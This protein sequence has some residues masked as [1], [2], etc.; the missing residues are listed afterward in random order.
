VGDAVGDMTRVYATTA[1][2]RGETAKEY[3]D[4]RTAASDAISVGKSEGGKAC[5]IFGPESSGLTNDDCELCFPHSSIPYSPFPIQTVVLWFVVCGFVVCDHLLEEKARHHLAAPS[6]GCISRLPIQRHG[7]IHY[8]VLNSRDPNWCSPSHSPSAD[9]A[10]HT[11]FISP[12][13]CYRLM[14]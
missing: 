3:M 6:V 10:P 9:D 1:R 13:Q 14:S 7:E 2:L 8:S 4:L 5:V 11:S 12:A